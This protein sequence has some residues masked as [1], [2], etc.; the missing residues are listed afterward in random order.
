MVTNR[1]QPRVGAR[2]SL[3]N[4]NAYCFNR[5]SRCPP[6]ITTNSGRC[7]GHKDPIWIRPRAPRRQPRPVAG[8]AAERLR[9]R[10]ASFNHYMATGALP[11]HPGQVN[12]TRRGLPFPVDLRRTDQ[13]GSVLGVTDMVGRVRLTSPTT[14]STAAPQEHD[15]ACAYEV[16]IAPDDNR[17]SEQWA[18]AVWKG[19]QH[20]SGGSCSLD[21]ALFSDFG[22]VRDIHQTTYS[23]GGSSTA[24]PTKP[25]VSSTP[26]SSLRT[27]CS[28][29][30]IEPSYGQPSSP[31]S[32]RWLGSFGPG[33]TASPPP[34][35]NRAPTSSQPLTVISSGMM[36]ERSAT[37]RHILAGEDR[38]A[39][40]NDA[41]L[42]GAYLCP[43][44]RT[45]GSAAPRG[46]RGPTRSRS[47]CTVPW[48]RPD[49]FSRG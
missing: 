9:Q 24:A 3:P 6:S 36:P 32:G 5:Y 26:G 43:A 27:T 1:E 47:A 29:G 11:Q 16:A 39:I 44:S 19:R 40:D 49:D 22:W 2:T 15:F 7:S 13:R 14:S 45:D 28:A 25:S 23:D 12:A 48:P 10:S 20:R 18:R 38:L 21:G 42:V 35:P 33:V 37:T 8:P 34:R 30:S 17:S 46:S 4:R 41:V 31:T